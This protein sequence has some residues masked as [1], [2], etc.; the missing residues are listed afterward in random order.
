M[1]TQSNDAQGAE[2]ND[3]SGVQVTENST[4]GE[5]LAAVTAQ[6]TQN[7][8]KVTPPQQRQ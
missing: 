6:L 8:A 2:N 4:A 1:S 5:L 3:S 7:L